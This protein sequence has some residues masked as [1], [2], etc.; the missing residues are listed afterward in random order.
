MDAGLDA[1]A[2]TFDLPQQLVGVQAVNAFLPVL[3]EEPLHAGRFYK[4]T[5]NI[6]LHF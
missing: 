5:E 4:K 3:G 1:D 2:L 6:H